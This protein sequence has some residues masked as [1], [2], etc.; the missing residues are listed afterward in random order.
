MEWWSWSWFFDGWTS[1]ARVVVCIP[2]VYLTTIAA[3]RVSGKRSTSQMNNFDW[4]VTVAMGSIVGSG[5]ILSTVRVA[6]ALVAVG[7]LLQYAVTSAVGRWAWAQRAAQASPAVLVY[8]GEFQDATLRAERVSR[9][10]VMA[11]IRRSGLHGPEAAEAVVLETDASISVIPMSGDD[12]IEFVCLHDVGGF[13]QAVSATED[14]SC[15][16]PG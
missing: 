12:D 11:A 2:V 9:Q 1:I 8:H 14:E 16:P 3:V 15:E 6:P 4:I 7:M 5:I 10:E 13:D